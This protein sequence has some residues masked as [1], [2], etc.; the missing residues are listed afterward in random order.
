MLH[1]NVTFAIIFA[2][3]QCARAQLSLK[4]NMNKKRNF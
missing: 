2:P 1:V 3:K 4:K